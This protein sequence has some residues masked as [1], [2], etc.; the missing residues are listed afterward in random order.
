M[1]LL[2]QNWGFSS[3]QTLSVNA[4]TVLRL[5]PQTFRYLEGDASGGLDCQG[6]ESSLTNCLSRVQERVLGGFDCLPMPV[7]Q[8]TNLRGKKVSDEKCSVTFF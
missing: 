4:S 2:W 5:S 8:A 1:F 3:M 7:L 6:E